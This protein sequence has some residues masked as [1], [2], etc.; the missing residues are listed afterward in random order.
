MI[1]LRPIAIIVAT[2]LWKIVQLNMLKKDF[3]TKYQAN[4]MT[5]R[6]M[7]KCIVLK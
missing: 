3:T 6:K 2:P 1:H 4:W 7:L 5:L